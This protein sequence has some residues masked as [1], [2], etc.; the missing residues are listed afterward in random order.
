MGFDIDVVKSYKSFAGNVSTGLAGLSKSSTYKEGFKKNVM[1]L[2]YFS[3]YHFF[4]EKRAN[5]STFFAANPDLET[6]A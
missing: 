2:T 5:Q 1:T 4:S 6:S 3:V